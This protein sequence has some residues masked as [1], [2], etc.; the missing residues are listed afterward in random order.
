MSGKNITRVTAHL[1]RE[2]WGDEWEARAGGEVSKRRQ[3]KRPP[4]LRRHAAEP[5]RLSILCVS[6]IIIISDDDSGGVAVTQDVAVGADGGGVAWPDVVVVY[7]QCRLLVVRTV[8][9]VFVAKRGVVGPVLMA[10][11]RHGNVVLL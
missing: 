9:V 3:A 10:F 4:L 6:T 1:V 8:A 5:R 7:Q 11:D 2:E